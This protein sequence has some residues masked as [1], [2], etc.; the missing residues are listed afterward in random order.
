MKC[1]V[2]GGDMKD[3]GLYSALVGVEGASSCSLLLTP[4]IGVRNLGIILELF[5]RGVGLMMFFREL[6]GI[7]IFRS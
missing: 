5:R 7:S 2:G 3:S 6:D 4:A 1:F